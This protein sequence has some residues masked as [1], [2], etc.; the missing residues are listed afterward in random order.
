MQNQQIP[1]QPK[2]QSQPVNNATDQSVQPAVNNKGTKL[3]IIEDD[4][5]LVKMYSTKCSM[6]GLQVDTA[7]DGQ[8][9]LEKLQKNN[10]DIILLDLM[11][12]K[13]DGFE[14]LEKLRA[15]AW[16]NAKKPVVVFSNLGQQSDIDRAKKLGANDYL[17]KANLTPNQVVEKL[18]EYMK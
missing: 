6:E 15:S 8:E 1:T 10:Y 18:H 5:L 14:V 13:V 17:V 16:P 2:G 4:E 11:L 9:A 7:L 12:P 3:L